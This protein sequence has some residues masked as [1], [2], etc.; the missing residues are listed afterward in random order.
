MYLDLVSLPS[1][2]LKLQLQSRSKLLTGVH[3]PQGICFD[4]VQGQD[5]S[6]GTS[7]TPRCRPI[8]LSCSVW[9]KQTDGGLPNASAKYMYIG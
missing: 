4:A 6:A 1:A 8:Y 3:S 5:G 2:N 7:I 9:R